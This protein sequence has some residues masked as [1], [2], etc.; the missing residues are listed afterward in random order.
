[1]QESSTLCRLAALLLALALSGASLAAQGID[2]RRVP[3]I[4]D[5]FTVSYAGNVI[6]R[7][8]T[9]RSRVEAQ[10]LQ[11]Y[12]WESRGGEWTIDSLFSDLVS[13][14]SEREIRVVRDTVIEVQFR[15][16]SS[17]VTLRPRNG[18]ALVRQV[19]IPSAPFSSAIL[20]ALASAAPLAEGYQAAFQFY[21]APPARYGTISISL[22]VR[23]SE[24]V[25][26]RD[27][28]RRLSWVVD[29]TTPS[30]GTTFWIDKATRSVVKYDTREGQAV[31]EFRR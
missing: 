15:N 13:L 11:V 31:I 5:T 1:M 21:F 16:D 19:G 3:L 28:V 25:V 29:A 4:T 2:G 20:D 6:G 22:R 17:I 9:A 12:R 18:P 26:G 10:L 24:D 30:G 14:R 8:I 7:G 27:G 23:G